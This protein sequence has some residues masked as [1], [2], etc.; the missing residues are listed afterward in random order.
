LRNK[1][2]YQNEFD[3]TIT[4]STRAPSVRGEHSQ[5]TKDYFRLLSNLSY[6]KE[7]KEETKAP[8]PVPPPL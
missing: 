4:T 8:A 5:A 6:E 3:A 7:K 2:K 1:E